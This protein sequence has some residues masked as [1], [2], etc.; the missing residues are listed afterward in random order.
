MTLHTSITSLE[1]INQL[2]TIKAEHTTMNAALDGNPGPF[3]L[4]DGRGPMTLLHLDRS[5]WRA[6]SD[7][8]SSKN[9][10]ALGYLHKHTRA[11]TSCFLLSGERSD[12][13]SDS[14]DASGPRDGPRGAR[15]SRTSLPPLLNGKMAQWAAPEGDPCLSCTAATWVWVHL[16]LN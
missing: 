1:I 3:S 2:R 10:R 16:R 8:F 7:T 4:S 14:G 13:Q 6:F 15:R 9:R 5:L 11:L 12:K